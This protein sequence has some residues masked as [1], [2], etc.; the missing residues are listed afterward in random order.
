MR[1]NQRKCVKKS[2]EA[3][4]N[5]GQAIEVDIGLFGSQFCVDLFLIGSESA[6][7]TMRWKINLEAFLSKVVRT[8][9]PALIA[10]LPKVATVV[11]KP[12]VQRLTEFV[13]APFESG[14]LRILVRCDCA[15][16]ALL[17]IENAAAGDIAAGELLLARAVCMV[18]SG[19]PLSGGE[20]RLSSRSRFAE[21]ATFRRRQAERQAQVACVDE[22]DGE[23]RFAG[24][25]QVSAGRD[26]RD[27]QLGLSAQPVVLL[28]PVVD[29]YD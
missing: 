29:L 23:P 1:V 13:D 24:C 17:S 18:L 28:F 9:N 20:H 14:L 27:V 8:P 15:L 2:H 6:C 19:G 10:R 22:S 3:D 4:A 7:V 26:G 5:K 16:L 11:S 21:R 25:H 12:H